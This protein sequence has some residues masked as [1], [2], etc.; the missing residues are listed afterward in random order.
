M[1]KS[2][3]KFVKGLLK[4]GP[5]VV[6]W[7][8]VLIAFN[9]AIPLYF[10]PQIEAIITIAVFLTGALLMIVLTHYFGFTRILGLGHILWIPLVGY[11]GFQLLGA[12]LSV[13]FYQWMA[14]TVVIDS[15][16]LI[17]DISDVIRYLRGDKHPLVEGL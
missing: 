9:F 5:F 12:P 8:G 3:L 15:I 4:M 6:L 17:I 11:L 13:T 1:F 7:L 14:G 10:W 16:S 2:L